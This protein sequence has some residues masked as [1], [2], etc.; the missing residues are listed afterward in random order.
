[1]IYLFML[2]PPYFVDGASH[3]KLRTLVT[4][5]A[6][7]PLLLAVLLTLLASASKYLKVGILIIAFLIFSAELFC[8]FDQ[9][10]RISCTVIII[11]LQ[12]DIQEASSFLSRST[13]IHSLLFTISTIA[14]ILLLFL[15]GEKNGVVWVASLKINLSRYRSHIFIRLWNMVFPRLW[16]C[17][18][19]FPDINVI[20]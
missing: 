20:I 15:F 2:L 19:L 17:V 11:A 10:T 4:C 13:S 6:P 5:L 1:M 14:A 18:A 16:W 12:S 7:Q 3:I 8:Y 9:S